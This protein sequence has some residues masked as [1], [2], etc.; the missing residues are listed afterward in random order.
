MGVY[1]S[2]TSEIMTVGAGDTK[3]YMYA[4]NN[5]AS[6]VTDDLNLSLNEDGTVREGSILGD[7]QM[8]N[9]LYITMIEAGYMDLSLQ[10]LY[11]IQ[12]LI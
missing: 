9:T 11:Q 8:Q 3:L 12:N 4:Q 7:L 6:D 10:K 1:R 2:A 5:T